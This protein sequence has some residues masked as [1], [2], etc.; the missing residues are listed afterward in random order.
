M[1][2][3]N[4]VSGY[5]DH[6]WYLLRDG[7]RFACA[8]LFLGTAGKSEHAAAMCEGWVLP[9]LRTRE[10]VAGELVRRGFHEVESLDLTPQVM[11]SAQAM[12]AV[13][14]AKKFELLL[15]QALAQ[16]P[17]DVTHHRHLEASLG[18]VAGLE[19]GAVTYGYEGSVRPAR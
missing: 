18:A 14:S 3:A 12:R 17:G 19:S 15:G 5:L 9:N 1:S 16:S 11:A 6:V 7:G 10:H 2:H 4:D 8:D 13:A